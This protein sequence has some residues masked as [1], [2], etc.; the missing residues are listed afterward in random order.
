MIGYITLAMSSI[1]AQR[2][3]PKDTNC[4]HLSFYPCLL[5]GRLAVSNDL[6][7]N[8]IGTYLADWSTGFALS[9][10]EQIGCR[11]VVLETKEDKVKFYMSCGFQ[12]GAALAAD[13]HVWMYKKI[14]I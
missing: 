8:D 2:L 14:A 3:D 1:L 11:Y 13:R 6:R 9:L 7:H 12:K 5:I 4:I 10:S